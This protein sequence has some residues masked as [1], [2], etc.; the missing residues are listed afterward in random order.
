MFKSLEQKGMPA[1]TEEG[2]IVRLNPMISTWREEAEADKDLIR[3]IKEHGQ[4]QAIVMRRMPDGA[5][6]LIAGHRRFYALRALKTPFKDMKVDI[7]EVDDVEAV[8]MAISENLERKDLTQVEI[9][10]ECGLR[11][12]QYIK[13]EQE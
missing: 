1:F 4:L 3:D 8:L 5:L 9:A 13:G 2:I 12:D 11:V 7:R 10:K 6:E